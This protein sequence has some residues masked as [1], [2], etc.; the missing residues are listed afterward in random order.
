[1]H[2]DVKAKKPA[3]AEIEGAVRMFMAQYM[4]EQ[5]K[6]TDIEPPPLMSLAATATTL[7]VCL[8]T[9]RNLI[10][11]GVLRSVHVGRRHLVYRDSVHAILEAK[12]G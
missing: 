5:A 4:S 7:G 1:M 12:A 9:V 10:K 6:P 8:L 3:H 2:K 11:R